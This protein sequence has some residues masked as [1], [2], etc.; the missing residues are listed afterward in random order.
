M[1][2]EVA[3]HILENLNPTELESLENAHWRYMHFIGIIGDPSPEDVEQANEDRKT[4]AHFLT[5]EVFDV[6]NAIQ[7]MMEIT[8]LPS[9]Y[10]EAW[11][12]C[13]F[14]KTNGISSEEAE[15]QSHI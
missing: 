12:E 5:M 1:K 14:F 6:E 8:G 7:F 2:L 9:D 10:C 13:D 4:F 11:D 15:N 3:Q